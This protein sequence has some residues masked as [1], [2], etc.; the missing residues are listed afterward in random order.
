MFKAHF[1]K[2]DH[3]ESCPPWAQIV[4]AKEEKRKIH[5]FYLYSLSLI[6]SRL[7]SD[8]F[9]EFLNGIYEMKSKDI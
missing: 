2:S 7:V 1:H 4:H 5:I 6:T 8:F 3:I 9:K